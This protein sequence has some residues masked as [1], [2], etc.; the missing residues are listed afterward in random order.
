M[1]TLHIEGGGV[2]GKSRQALRLGFKCFFGKFETSAGKFFIPEV[3]MH[4]PNKETL[5][6]FKNALEFRPD[7]HHVLLVDSDSQVTKNAIQHLTDELNWNFNGIEPN[8]VHLMVQ[9]MEAWIIADP[10][11]LLVFYGDGFKSERFTGLTDVEEISTYNLDHWLGS[12][13]SETTAKKYH[14]I[15]HASELLKLI[16]RNKVREKATHCDC[17]FKHLE[18]VHQNFVDN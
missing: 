16:N 1:V 9:E 2:S 18:K 14:K 13:T 17:L 5:D 10:D 12:A 7:E 11:A 3:E 8:I 4:G 6:R 15:R